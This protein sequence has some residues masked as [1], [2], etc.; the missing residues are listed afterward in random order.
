MKVKLKK[1][2]MD[3]AFSYRG[4]SIE[5]WAALNKGKTVEVDKI[6]KHAV[7]FVEEV[8]GVKVKTKVNEGDK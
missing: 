6:S 8:K 5:D 3:N 4:F 1:D 2:K 7:N